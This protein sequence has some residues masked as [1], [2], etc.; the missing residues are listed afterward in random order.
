MDARTH[1]ILENV[2]NIVLSLLV[3]AAFAGL[4]I[5]FYKNMFAPHVFFDSTAD[6]ILFLTAATDGLI[7]VL[8]LFRREEKHGKLFCD[9]EKLTVLIVCHNGEVLIGETIKQALVHVP[10]KHIIVISDASTDDTAEVARSFGVRVFE[11]EESL[12]KSMSINFYASH[13]E[14]PYT[15]I[16][17]DDTHIGH[18]VIPTNLLD[19]DY[20]AVAFNVMPAVRPGLLN[21]LQRFEYRKSMYFGKRQ[22]SD[23][24]SIGNVSGA[25]GLFHTK[26]LI[27]QS[28]KHSGQYGGEDQQRTLLLHL[29]GSHKKG[30]TFCDTLVETEAPATAAKLFKQRATKWNCSVN[31]LFILNMRVVFHSNTHFLLKTERAYKLFIFGTEPIRILAAFFSIFH[32]ENILLLYAF[33]FSIEVAAWSRMGRKDHPWIL[34]LVPGYNLLKVKAGF[35]A[36]FWWF[37]MKYDYVVRKKF[38]QFVTGRNLPREY[39]TTATLILALSGYAIFKFIIFL[40]A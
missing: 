3:I 29:E 13:I 4:V 1:I 37:K 40:S 20:S 2:K 25:I 22:R 17:D 35:I 10:P 7:F 32:P 11:N 23:S 28:H 24:G 12:N 8:S 36:Y 18:T 5:Y 16:L 15:L 14:T 38:Y 34:P 31:E 6:R 27:A 9:P 19:E 33:Y 39:A 26:D 21:K 30:V